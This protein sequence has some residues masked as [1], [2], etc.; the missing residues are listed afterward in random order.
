M[1]LLESGWRTY[2]VDSV[3]PSPDTEEYTVGLY[4][5]LTELKLTYD[6]GNKIGGHRHC[7]LELVPDPAIP[8][9]STNKTM[10]L[11]TVE[12]IMKTAQI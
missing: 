8:T 11:L 2:L 12:L 1:V 5:T 7:I 3:P 10:S 9:L 4:L 6:E